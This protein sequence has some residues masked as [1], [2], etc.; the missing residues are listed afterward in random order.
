MVK[1]LN[2]EI[3]SEI[4]SSKLNKPFSQSIITAVAVIALV[5]EAILNILSVL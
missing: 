1:S 5:C 4:G 3:Y 2:S